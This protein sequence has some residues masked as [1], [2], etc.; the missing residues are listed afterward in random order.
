MISIALTLALVIFSI[1]LIKS[2]DLV[3][4]A[5]RR[6]ND[7]LKAG[8]FALSAIIL[9]I[10]TSLPELF[11][12]ITSALEGSPNLSLGNVIGAN[13]A[14]I[15]LVAG[16]GAVFAGR[17]RVRGKILGREMLL[18]LG[19]GILPLLL[20][21]DKNLSRVDGLILLSAYLAYATSLFRSRFT[22]IA[23]EQEEETSFVYRFVR[24]FTR[25]NGTYRREMGR[26]F[27]GVALLL[28]SADMIVRIAQYFANS[29]NLP[30]F[31]VGLFL[32]SI[33]TTLP[34]IAFS[35]RSL[36]DH[37]PSMFFGNLLGSIVANSTLVL[38]IVSFITPIQ[39]VALNEYLVSAWTFVITTLI[40]WF[41]TRSKHRLDRWEAALLLIVYTIFIMVIFL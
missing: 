7:K 24:E 19:S 31:I 26:L 20:I 30:I 14:N 21:A 18:A 33:G 3:I 32:L 2:A 8:V 10:G 16:L 13:I 41:F 36:R 37:E 39:I 1:I 25:A 12:G 4:T 17:V 6:I 29:L 35:F 34:E 22:E 11:V 38:G 28:F 9:A 23:Q 5:L 40:F 15:S 27:V